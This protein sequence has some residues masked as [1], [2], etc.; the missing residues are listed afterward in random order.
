MAF[1]EKGEGFMVRESEDYYKRL[2]E[3][4]RKLS[5]EAEWVEFKR[6]NDNPQ[7]IGEY[8]SA[9]SNSATL[10]GKSKAY[11]LWGID[12]ATH[13]I[14]GTSFSPAK[15]KKGNQELENWLAGLTE[16]KVDFIFTE[17]MID[18][19]KVVVLEISRATVSPVSFGGTEFIRIGSYKKKLKEFPEKER[20]LW[21]SFENTPYELRTATSNITEEEVTELLD[22]AAY[23]TLL[24]LPLPTNRSA[25]IHKMLDE[26]FIT[27]MDNGNYEITNM[28]ALLLAKNL[29]DF[30][31]LKRKA[32]RVIQYK[33]NGRTTALREKVF[34]KGYAVEFD[35]ICDYINTLVPQREEIE[36]GSRIEHRM[37]PEKAIREM[38]SN[39]IIHQQLDIHGAGPMM[40]I[41][42][43]RIEASNPGGMLVDVNRI[44]DTAPHARNES[45][46][47]FLRIARICEERGSGFDRIEESM[48]DLKIPAPKVETSVG[49]TRVKLYWYP[50]LRDWKKEDRVRTCYLATCYYYVNEIEV[51]NSVLRERFGIEEKNKAIM[52]RIIKETMEAGLI[53]LTDPTAAAK[54]RKYIPYWA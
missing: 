33:G 5:A 41:F 38:V 53:K 20:E 48:G 1:V 8:I 37:F 50:R 6:D 46:A 21:K 43:T 16:P 34:T 24:K 3:R 52:S 9:L 49:F 30:R 32:I 17:V 2:I 4:L 42:E 35:D 31:S 54:S 26:G 12:D 28:G 15:A 7:M 39:L 45:M 36:S 27:E 29:N 22:C 51:T 23:Y 47:S 14:V 25:M 18:G 44:I 10:N 13:E 11:L 19:K 40:E